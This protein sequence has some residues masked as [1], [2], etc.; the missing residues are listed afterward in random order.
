MSNKLRKDNIITDE[1]VKFESPLLSSPL[2]Q[3]KAIVD[4]KFEELKEIFE[5]CGEE[6][7]WEKIEEQTNKDLKGFE[8]IIQ[9]KEIYNLFNRVISGGGVT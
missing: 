7:E 1:V 3:R 5:K 6:M 4:S 8:N 9:P 2:G